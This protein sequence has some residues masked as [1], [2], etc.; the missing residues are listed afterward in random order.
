VIG[1]LLWL[2]LFIVIAAFVDWRLWV[3]ITTKR[4]AVKGWVFA[5]SEQPTHYWA[6]VGLNF[7]AALMLS[8]LA[9]VLILATS[10]KS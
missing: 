1:N 2:S 7:L 3:S 4:A 6:V 9:A 8:A 10:S 5:R